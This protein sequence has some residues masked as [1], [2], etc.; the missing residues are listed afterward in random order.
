[1]TV[2]YDEVLGSPE[3]AV[4]DVLE[5]TL[6]VAVLLLAAAY[7]EMH[8]I[9]RVTAPEALAA[10]DVVDSARA[11]AVLVDRYR[12]ELAIAPTDSAELPF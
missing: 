4:L 10:L 3:L 1:M 11:L 8:D 5:R 9:D 6:D 12:H 7:P 2:T